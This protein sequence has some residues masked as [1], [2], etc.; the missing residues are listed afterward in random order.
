MLSD[1]ILKARHL[2]L[3]KKFLEVFSDEQPLDDLHQ[4]F[5]LKTNLTIKQNS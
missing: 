5:L 2:G 3:N 4:I 1:C